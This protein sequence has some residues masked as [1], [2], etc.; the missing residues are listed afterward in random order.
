MPPRQIAGRV[1]GQAVVTRLHAVSVVLPLDTGHTIST[2]P[3]GSL[4]H[5]SGQGAKKSNSMLCSS[6]SVG[7]WSVHHQAPSLT[8]S[9]KV[10]IINADSSSTDNL[11]STSRCLKYLAINLCSRAND[12]RINCLNLLQ[13]LVTWEVIAAIDI[14]NRLQKVHSSLTELLCHKDG[15][16]LISLSSSTCEY[17]ENMS[18]H[19]QKRSG[20][21]LV[22]SCPNSDNSTYRLEFF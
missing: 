12:N 20:Q 1:A 11:E 13:Q 10:D 2:R 18:G 19:R 7:S 17:V 14:S 6:D 16:S 22:A 9:S 5:I 15:W 21:T 8:G 4:R 3:L